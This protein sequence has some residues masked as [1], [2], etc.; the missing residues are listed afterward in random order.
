MANWWQ[1]ITESTGLTNYGAVEDAK[2]AARENAALSSQTLEQNKQFLEQMKRSAQGTYGAGAA[3]YDT[4]LKNYLDTPDYSAER[5]SYDKDVSS[6]MDPAYKLRVQQAMNGIQNSRANAGGMFSSDTINEIAAKQQAMAS[7]EF[8]NAYNRLMQDKS[9]SLSEWQANNDERRQQYQSELA[10]ASQLLNLA[11]SDRQQ[12]AN[13][14]NAYY[15]NLINANNANLQTQ[16]GANQSKANAALQQQGLGSA[17]TRILT[18][19]ALA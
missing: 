9:A 6:F 2:K 11:N 18:A 14:N 8:A 4:A 1:K 13:A 12:L 15:T 7:E 3:G 16:A 5:F 10:K 19:A 17:L